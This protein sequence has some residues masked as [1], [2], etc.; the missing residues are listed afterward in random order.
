MNRFVGLVVVMQKAK[1]YTWNKTCNLR[2][3]ALTHCFEWVH[4]WVYLSCVCV[5]VCER[6][7][8]KSEREKECLHSVI[9]SCWNMIAGDCTFSL[10]LP[11]SSSNPSPYLC[12]GFSALP[13]HVHAVSLTQSPCWD[14]NP[15]YVDAFQYQVIRIDDIIM[16]QIREQHTS[17]SSYSTFGFLRTRWYL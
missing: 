10:S 7:K 4:E 12:L 6:E 9:V 14:W 2:D 8:R 1:C 13:P 17:P 5:C 16:I 11:I 3:C 15:F